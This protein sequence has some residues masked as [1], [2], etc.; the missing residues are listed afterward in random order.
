MSGLDTIKLNKYRQDWIDENE[1]I[2]KRNY[3]DWINMYMKY[4]H[5]ENEISRHEYD[6]EVE[7]MK[8]DG[9][10]VTEPFILP[11]A[12]ITPS[13]P[14]TKEG[15]KYIQGLKHYINSYK[16][17]HQYRKPPSLQMTPIDKRCV[18][19]YVKKDNT[20]ETNYTEMWN[21]MIKYICESPPDI[22]EATVKRFLEESPFRYQKRCDYDS[23][24]VGKYIKK[25]GSWVKIE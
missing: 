14:D 12:S 6:E 22:A 4:R 15:K 16:E 13:H 1:T 11:Y 10:T 9:E 20:R 21:E 8:E 19:S 3:T 5:R 18:K 2:N 25:D 7:Y 17:T 24:S 23:Q